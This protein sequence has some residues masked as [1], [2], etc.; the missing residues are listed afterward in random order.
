M[1]TPKPLQNGK[2][3]TLK[4]GTAGRILGKKL[5]NPARRALSKAKGALAK[6]I[7]ALKKKKGWPG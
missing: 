1:P 4:K 7:R 6:K 2:Q 5:Y 3:G